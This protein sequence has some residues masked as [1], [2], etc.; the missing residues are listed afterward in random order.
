[1][2]H[3]EFHSAKITNHNHQYIR[4]FKGLNLSVNWQSSTSAWF[5]VIV[6]AVMDLFCTDLKSATPM[7]SG[8]VFFLDFIKNFFDL[9]F[10]AD[11]KAISEELTVFFFVQHFFGW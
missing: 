10:G 3:P 5:S 9:I 4:Y 8:I 7:S 1:S 11:R 2:A 6:G